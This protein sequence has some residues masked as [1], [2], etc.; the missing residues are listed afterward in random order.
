MATQRTTII[1]HNCTNPNC[2]FSIFAVQ[3]ISAPAMQEPCPQCGSELEPNDRVCT[4][5]QPLEQRLYYSPVR[6]A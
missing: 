5:G 3:E 4:S 6:A 2:R 1:R